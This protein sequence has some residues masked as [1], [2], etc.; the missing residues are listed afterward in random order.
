[1]ATFT[2]KN[3]YHGLV[4]NG[5][6]TLYTV[7]AST[8]TIVKNIHIANTTATAATISIWVDNN[9]TTAGDAEAIL[10]TFNIPAND[11]VRI[12]C[13]EIMAA[14]STIKATAGTT[15]VLS[16]HINGATLT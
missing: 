2:E 11:Y 15:N 8:T 14:A 6:D 9:G 16:V 13:Y 7:P 5:T 12:N 3:L 1:M 4:T 10:K